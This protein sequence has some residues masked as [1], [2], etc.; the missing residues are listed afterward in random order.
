MIS[1]LYLKNGQKIIAL[2]LEKISPDDYNDP[3]LVV[4]NP[5]EVLLEDSGCI[6]IVRYLSDYTE[7]NIFSFRTEDVLTI[8]KPN[9]ELC[10]QYNILNNIEEQLELTITSDNDEATEPESL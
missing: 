3:D 8:F 9:P 4:E 7:Q 2:N 1:G 6:N 10:K 5:Y